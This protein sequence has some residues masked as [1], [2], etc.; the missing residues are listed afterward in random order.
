MSIFPEN[1][2]S[3]HVPY[4]HFGGGT[5]PIHVQIWLFL[6]NPFSDHT[7]ITWTCFTKHAF[8]KNDSASGGNVPTPHGSI[9]H[10]SR[11]SQ[12]PYRQKINLF[13]LH[14]LLCFC[15]IDPFK[16]LPKGIPCWPKL[17]ASLLARAK[18]SSKDC[19]PCVAPHEFWEPE[20]G[21]C[22]YT[23]HYIKFAWPCQRAC[24][25]PVHK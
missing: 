6:Q 3:S 2:I 8:F 25:R 11:G 15:P 17:G 5:W 12:V 21:C 16:G 18:L 20:G 4:G 13:R 10:P 14:F 24:T 19:I 9:L 7:H 22:T 1:V 23:P